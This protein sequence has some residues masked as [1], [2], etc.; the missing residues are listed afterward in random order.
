MAAVDEPKTQEEREEVEADK[1]AG[2]IERRL[3]LWRNRD[4]LIMWGGQA[5]SWVGTSASAIV[6]PLLLLDITGSP[7]AA[8]VAGALGSLPYV[9]FSLPFGALIDRW[10]RKKVMVL[11]DAAR[12]IV[13]GSIPVASALGAL[14]IWQLYAASALEGTFF[15]LFNLAESAAMPHVVPKSQLPQ[16]L[17]QIN[18]VGG[19]AELVGPSLGTLLYQA[20]GRMVPFMLDAV[21]YGVSVATLLM[22]RVKLQTERVQRGEM[23]RNLRAEIGEGIHWWW[24]QPLF[25]YLAFLGSALNLLL[26]VLPLLLIVLAKGRGAQDVEIGL[27]FS[28][29]AVG[30]IFGSLVAGKLQK[31]ISFGKA[32]D[33]VLWFRVLVFPLFLVAPNVLTLALV[34]GLLFFGE[35]LYNVVAYTYRLALIPDELQGRVNSSFRMVAWSSRPVGAALGGLLLEHAGGVA[36]V[37]ACLVAIVLM[38]AVTQFNTHVQNAPPLEAY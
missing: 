36:T 31:R 34:N 28:V 12:A 6:F 8:G 19:T 16:A 33:L 27:I 24:S 25:R 37:I 20:V 18:A 4:F 14:T 30:G 21:S 9:F 7:A 26:G 2:Q 35:P 11:C 3:S 15:V 22:V 13:F 29:G 1:N 32:I 38:A 5:V 10:D 17:A 23:R